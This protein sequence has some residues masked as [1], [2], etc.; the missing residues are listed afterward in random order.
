MVTRPPASPSVCP[1]VRAR[2][3]RTAHESCASSACTRTP[4]SSATP[5]LTGFSRFRVIPR[6]RRPDLRDGPP[7]RD[8]GTA[9]GSQERAFRRRDDGVT[10]RVPTVGTA[11]TY[12]AYAW[13]DQDRPSLHYSRT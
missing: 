8:R 5:W 2:R 11:Y 1:S 6:P 10:S 4:T 3:R 12:V 9:P 7:L 13:G